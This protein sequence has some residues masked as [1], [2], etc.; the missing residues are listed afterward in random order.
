MKAYFRY[1]DEQKQRYY[2]RLSKYDV[3]TS[4][5]DT[6]FSYRQYKNTV[7]I[8]CSDLNLLHHF[9]VR[10]HTVNPPQKGSID[11][12]AESL[13]SWQL[14]HKFPKRF[15]IKNVYNRTKFIMDVKNFFDITDTTHIEDTYDKHFQMRGE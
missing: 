1:T 3:W 6:D 7:Q 10:F 15:D 4:T 14:M 8:F 11:E 12:Y 9:A 5:T 13:E 2:K